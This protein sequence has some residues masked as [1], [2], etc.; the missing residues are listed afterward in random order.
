MRRS[1]TLAWTHETIARVNHEVD[2]IAGIDTD[3]VSIE[4]GVMNPGKRQSVRHNGLS[5]RP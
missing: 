1:I 3:E 2:A 5:I 4:G